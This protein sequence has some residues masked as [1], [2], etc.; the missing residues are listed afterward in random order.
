MRK[1]IKARI[2]TPPIAPPAIGPT[3]GFF[4]D[5]AGVG[6]V[7]GVEVGVSDSVADDVD[8]FVADA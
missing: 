3:F 6:V 2:A 5:A 1:S 7:V 8:E 4:P